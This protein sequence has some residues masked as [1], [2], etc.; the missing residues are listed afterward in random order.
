[1]P[2]KLISLLL[3]ISML[4]C[5]SA[6]GTTETGSNPTHTPSESQMDTVKDNDENIFSEENSQV[7]SNTEGRNENDT[8]QTQTQT[9]QSKPTST[10][11]Q[12]THTHSYSNATCTS[13][14]KCSCGATDG[15]ALGHS[16]A[17]ASCAVPE[18]CI[19]CGLTNGEPL[20]HTYVNYVCARC[21]TQDPEALPVSLHLLPVIDSTYECRYYDQILTDNFG[22]SYVGYHFFKEKGN[23]PGTTI[24]YLN[25]EYTHFSCDVLTLCD[26]DQE[27]SFVIYVDN[28]IIYQSDC[29]DRT[30]GRIHIDIDVKN[31]QQL[32]ISS[33]NHAGS[34]GDTIY[35]V[36]AQVSKM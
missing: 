31:G 6:C 8:T 12:T 36:N 2:N 26:A 25:K 23:N 1:M 24:F 17:E 19:R 9:N 35:V 22:N 13:P 16:Y 21:G 14:K 29:F 30:D 28:Q 5:L 3:T 7:S 34:W 11:N 15:Q 27:V 32:K 10:T 4:S 20:G 18:K 33:W